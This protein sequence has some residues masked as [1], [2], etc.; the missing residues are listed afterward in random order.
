VKPSDHAAH[1]LS[2]GF[3]ICPLI[4]VQFAPLWRRV[5]AVALAPPELVAFGIS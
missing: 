2:I 5:L 4:G 1:T 3:Q